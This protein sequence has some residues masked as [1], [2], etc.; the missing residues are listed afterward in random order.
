MS[1]REKIANEDIKWK[2][3]E[4]KGQAIFRKYTTTWPKYIQN[5]IKDDKPKVTF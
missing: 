4:K 3:Y 2:E 1:N 5:R